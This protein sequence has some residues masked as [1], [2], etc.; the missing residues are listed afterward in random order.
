M[1]W[2]QFST[3]TV[4]KIVANNAIIPEFLETLLWLFYTCRTNCGRPLHCSFLCTWRGKKRFSGEAWHNSSPEIP[5]AVD[6]VRT[7]ARI[8][9]DEP[10]GKRLPIFPQES[11]A[12][13]LG[14]TY[15]YK[16][17]ATRYSSL[18]QARLLWI[19]CFTWGMQIKIFGINLYPLRTP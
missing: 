9:S 2:F 11:G 4:G 12:P 1:V 6:R 16:R 5:S 10:K 14:V 19:S 13:N 17:I 15:N 8:Q 7:K 18:A 3:R